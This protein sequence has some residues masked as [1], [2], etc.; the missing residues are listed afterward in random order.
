METMARNVPSLSCSGGLTVNVPTVS[1][2]APFKSIGTEAGDTS[3]PCGTASLS[4]P[5]TGPVAAVTC[6]ETDFR[7]VR[8]KYEH[9]VRDVREN[10][11]RNN[12]RVV[13]L[14]PPPGQPCGTSCPQCIAAPVRSP[15][16]LFRPEDQGGFSGRPISFLIIHSEGAERAW[17]AKPVRLR[18][19]RILRN[20]ARHILRDEFVR[21]KRRIN[22]HRIA[23]YRKS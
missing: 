6:T 16:A 4:S 23:G 13:A 7:L 15:A 1:A 17:F 9:A 2:S 3:H 11:W 18:I 20:L 21:W 22:F 10:R 14:R 8:R 19:R 5:F 12:Q